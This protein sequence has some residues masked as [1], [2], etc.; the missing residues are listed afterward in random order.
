MVLMEE[1]DPFHVLLVT[2]VP[3]SA[4]PLAFVADIRFVRPPEPVLLRLRMLVEGGA[5]CVCTSSSSP[6]ELASRHGDTS[7][8]TTL[9]TSRALTCLQS[10]CE[11]DS[12]RAPAAGK[13]NGS[14]AHAR[15]LL[16]RR[17][18]E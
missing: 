11:L 6:G 3:G 16:R 17:S 14:F 1:G 4:Q 7:V 8:R 15:C 12:G 2:R 9:A 10:A 5:G 18:L 13:M